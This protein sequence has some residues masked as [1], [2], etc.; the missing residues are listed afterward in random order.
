MLPAFALFGLIVPNGMFIYWLL[1][2]FHGLAAVFDDWLAVS[3]ILDAVLAL[4][5]LTIY[6]AR[7]PIGRVKWPWFVVMSLAGGLGFSLPMYWWLNQ[8]TF[9]ARH[10]MTSIR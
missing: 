7:N 9:S 2:D 10:P 1:H 6:F 3:F 8:R 4:I 5:L